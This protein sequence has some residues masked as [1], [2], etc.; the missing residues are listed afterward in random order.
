MQ[1]EFE[2]ARNAPGLFVAAHPDGT[3]ITSE[4]PAHVGEQITIFGTG[5]GPYQP[6]PLDGFRIPSDRAFTL[7]DKI[8]VIMQG[9]SVPYDSGIAAAGAVGVA[10]I[11]V[12]IPEDLDLAKPGTLMVQVQAGD[13]SSNT[14]PL[15]LK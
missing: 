1:V 12:R 13:A 14:L 7:A 4:S 9:R 5:L 15:P 11:Q 8:A 3:T 10:L 2:V 6:M